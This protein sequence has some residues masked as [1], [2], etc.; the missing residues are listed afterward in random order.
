MNDSRVGPAP[1]AITVGMPV[2]NDGAF[3]R[4][5]L[6]SVL[7][8]TFTD[9]TLI[10]SDDASTDGSERICQEYAG[11]DARITFVQ[12]PRNLGISRNMRF[13]RDQAR[14]PYFAWVGDDDVWAD[15]FLERLWRSLEERPSAVVA[16]CT[17][18]L[19]D[20]LGR[21]MGRERDFDYG[22]ATPAR[23][24][25][26]FLQES[27]DCFG[28]GLIRAAAV[29]DAPFPRWPWPNRNQ[30]YN[31]IFPS[32]CHYLVE[33]DYVH[34]SGAPLY[35]KR[36][37]ATEARRHNRQAGSGA[38]ELIR[39]TTRRF[40]LACYSAAAI[41]RAGGVFLGARMLPRL[42]YRWFVVAAGRE[43]GAALAGKWAAR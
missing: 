17:Y 30:A 31:N 29:R 22:A 40:Y 36:V 41:S 13:L 42:F 11:K 25:K 32:L 18:V 2:F 19:M 5:A 35:F 34:I 21:P 10:I 23:R 4:Q 43:W 27:D 24:L 14:S 20:E 1:P 7:A 9:F 3:L 15:R 26:H 37:K 39:F 6:D 12:Q 28:Y 33:G 16:F 38:W 8:Q